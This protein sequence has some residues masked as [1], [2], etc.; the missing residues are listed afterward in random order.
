MA[1]TNDEAV[2][3]RLREFL[4]DKIGGCLG[5]REQKESFALYA[6]GIVSRA[7]LRKEPCPPRRW[8][9]IMS[10][11]LLKV[12]ER[13]KRDGNFGGNDDL[14]FFDDLLAY[15]EQNYCIDSSR[16]FVTGQSWGGDMTQLLTCMRGSV[17]RAGVGVAAN[18]DYYLP[19]AAGECTGNP[20]SFTLHGIDDNS[21]PFARGE[22]VRDFWLREHGCS[23]ETLP[24]A[25]DQCVQFQ[26]CVAPTVFCPYGPGNGGHQIPDYYSESTMQRF[27]SY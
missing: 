16:V 20:D 8:R 9:E 13:A 27:H 3:S 4:Y 7:S 11:K 19:P 5:R 14:L 12:M 6:H 2:G 26:G 15:L 23:Q 24:V 25:P 18:G 21:I 1:L 22:E 17:L 10:P